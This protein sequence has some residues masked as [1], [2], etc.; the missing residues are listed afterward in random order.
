[1]VTSAPLC[2]PGRV[3]GNFVWADRAEWL[4][5]SSKAP[6]QS[7]RERNGRDR[8]EGTSPSGDEV[9]PA[10]DSDRVGV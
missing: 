4:S 6:Q 5:R 7:G 2:S 8:R 1:M 10:V 3:T 9:V